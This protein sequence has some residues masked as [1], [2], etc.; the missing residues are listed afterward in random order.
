VRAVEWR[1]IGGGE[2]EG[3]DGR[4]AVEWRWIGGGKG[5][6]VGGRVVARARA[7]AVE[8]WSSGGGS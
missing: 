6:G 3:V 8:W 1:W 4:V 2:G 7:L 5:E